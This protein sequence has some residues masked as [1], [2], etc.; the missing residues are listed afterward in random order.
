MN[1]HMQR[2]QLLIQQDRYELAEPELRLA[3]AE[4]SNNS[5]AHTLLA[6]C[7]R[8]QERF[9]EATAEVRLAIAADPLE[10]GGY[11]ELS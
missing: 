6:V 2:A 5:L 9:E 4:D 1:V 10:A 8:H 7:L 3:L 11:S